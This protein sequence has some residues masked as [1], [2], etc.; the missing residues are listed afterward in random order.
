LEQAF[1]LSQSNSI[2]TYSNDSKNNYIEEYFADATSKRI[3][4]D[5]KVTKM[6]CLP[7]FSYDLN[8]KNPIL[9]AL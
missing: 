7:S 8:S 9:L 6:L 2:V 4:I 3:Q 1:T 5:M